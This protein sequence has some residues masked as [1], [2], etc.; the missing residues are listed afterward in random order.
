MESFL[1]RFDFAWRTMEM[2]ITF[3]LFR[4]QASAACSTADLSGSINGEV[5]EHIKKEF[6]VVNLIEAY[7]TRGHLFTKTN[8]VRERRHYTPTLDIE[9]FG[10][11]KKI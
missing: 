11:S 10:L 7:R 9:N 5:P 6:K 1:S 8:P 2:T 3:N 4:L